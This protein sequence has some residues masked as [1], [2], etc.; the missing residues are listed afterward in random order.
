[1]EEITDSNLK[2][3]NY[4]LIHLYTCHFDNLINHLLIAVIQF[5]LVYHFAEMIKCDD[6]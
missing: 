3:T 1:M 6:G 4:N 2:V 5:K